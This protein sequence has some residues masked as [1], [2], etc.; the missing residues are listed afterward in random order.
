MIKIPV[1]SLKSHLDIEVYLGRRPSSNIEASGRL[2]QA[3]AHGRHARLSCF[4]S[5]PSSPKRIKEFP[6]S[7]R[8]SDVD[9]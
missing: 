1:A 3:Q 8:A 9:R 2:K 5:Q 6:Q 7:S 4:L